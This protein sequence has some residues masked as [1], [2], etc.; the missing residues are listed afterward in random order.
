MRCSA[1]IKLSYRYD[2]V[3]YGI[4]LYRLL[5]FDFPALADQ[6]DMFVDCVAG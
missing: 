1:F 5:L 6:S 3:W 4:L 2:I